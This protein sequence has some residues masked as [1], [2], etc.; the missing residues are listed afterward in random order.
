MSPAREHLPQAYVWLRPPRAVRQALAQH[1]EQWWWPEGH[2][3][4]RADRLHLTLHSLGPLTDDE[5]GD[6]ERA[7]RRA[8]H[9]RFDLSLT[10]SGLHDHFDLAI[11][12][13]APNATLHLLYERLRVSMPGWVHQRRSRWR[14]HVTLAWDT[15]C[16]GIAALD[17]IAW[18]VESFSLIRSWL[19]ADHVR[20]A[21]LARYE[22][23]EMS[24]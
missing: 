24:S 12:C 6:V 20:H 23:Q 3:Q 13:P 11:A 22:L 2:H 21:E 18:P 4:P 19:Q 15:P 9:P 14:P 7:L 8:R 17:P 10:W 5:L 16:A 1:R